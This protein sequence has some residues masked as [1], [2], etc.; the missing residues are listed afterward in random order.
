MKIVLE[1]AGI[2]VLYL[3]AGSGICG[4]LLWVIDQFSAF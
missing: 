3:T 4:M 2:A 1:Q